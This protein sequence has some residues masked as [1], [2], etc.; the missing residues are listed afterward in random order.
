MCP[1]CYTEVQGTVNQTRDYYSILRS[2]VN[3]LAGQNDPTTTFEEKRAFALD[4][5][6]GLE[7]DIDALVSQY[8]Q[9]YIDVNQ[10][11]LLTNKLNISTI[12]LVELIA[13]AE[14]KVSPYAKL[15]E[16]A[17]LTV[18]ALKNEIYAGQDVLISIET[19][20]YPE[21][22][23]N[24]DYLKDKAMRSN[25]TLDELVMYVEMLEN[26]TNNIITL[27]EQATDAATSS[28]STATSLVTL[29]NDNNNSLSIVQA[30]LNE[31][32]SD[33]SLA[34]QELAAFNMSII[35]AQM[36]IGNIEAKLPTLP[37]K[38]YIMSQISKIDQLQHTTNTI[39]DSYNRQ[40]TL[41]RSLN[42]SLANI[43]TDY[44]NI[45]L[46]LSQTADT[47]NQY[48]DDFTSIF[49]KA[50]TASTKAS[51]D[52]LEAESILVDL[53]N[54]SNATAALK[55][56]AD[57]ALLMAADI[58]ETINMVEEVVSESISQLDDVSVQL[59]ELL[60][61]SLSLQSDSKTVNE[62]CDCVLLLLVLL[63]LLLL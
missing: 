18:N 16:S 37:S 50:T 13:I 54:F 60:S 56:K 42:N 43:Q 53:M 3:A 48:L 10:L 58:N 33:L 30:T 5:V 62:V 26:Q 23:S 52:L 24:T 4:Q 32:D 36:S 57:Q 49:D 38:S 8:G 40:W 12:T 29:S 14:I 45:Q 27:V 41:F 22:L 51:T 35:Y 20:I 39:L 59:D 25:V 6:F 19:V 28:L 15:V 63:V 34:V 55:A 2:L 17:K 31:L 9:L 11:L 7:S 1:S 44:N 21:I 47:I 46:L 61:A